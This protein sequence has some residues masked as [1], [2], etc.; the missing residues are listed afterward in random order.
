MEAFNG[1]TDETDNINIL[2]APEGVW[3]SG[4]R[5]V[6]PISLKTTMFMELENNEAAVS[7]HIT[8]LANELLLLVGTVKDYRFSPKQGYS[9]AYL[10]T[11]RFL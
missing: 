10:Y 1:G 9:A 3:A 8:M 11:F 6:E 4:I 5:L 2:R 7:I